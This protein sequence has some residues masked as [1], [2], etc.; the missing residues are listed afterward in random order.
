M[1]TAMEREQVSSVAKNNPNL[2]SLMNFKMD[3]KSVKSEPLSMDEQSNYTVFKMENM[4]Y[5]HDQSM[6]FKTEPDQSELMKSSH[7]LFEPSAPKAIPVSVENGSPEIREHT[8][9]P[10]ANSDMIQLKPAIA[11]SQT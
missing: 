1:T 10:E 6:V 2:S 4:A 7:D 9:G 11:V 3:S 5:K 8:P